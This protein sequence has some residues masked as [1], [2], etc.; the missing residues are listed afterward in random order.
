MDNNLVVCIATKE[1]CK[2]LNYV[3]FHIFVCQTL[4]K[5][6]LAKPAKK[7]KRVNF[8]AFISLLFSNSKSDTT[9][10]CGGSLCTFV[11]ILLSLSLHFMINNVNLNKKL[12]HNFGYRKLVF[13]FASEISYLL[14]LIKIIHLKL[15]IL[16]YAN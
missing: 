15:N 2:R 16:F 11:L 4:N 12:F 1:P 9:Q 5:V 14:F 10:L 3:H 6:R 7:Q 8:L 13:I